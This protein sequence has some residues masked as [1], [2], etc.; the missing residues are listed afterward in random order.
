MESYFLIS[1]LFISSSLYKWC[2]PIL[3]GLKWPRKSCKCGF[4]W[5]L[6]SLWPQSEPRQVYVH[7]L[8]W[9]PLMASGWDV[10]YPG[11][12]C[13][14]HLGKCLGFQFLTD[15]VTKSNFDDVMEK[16]K[17]RLASWKG[18]LLNR[19]GHLCLTN[20]VLAST[21][22]YPMQAL[23]FPHSMCTKLDQ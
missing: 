4:A 3:W 22:I 19:G 12:M 2:S 17:S 7:L 15:Q 20:L 14:N 8:T 23:W 6:W 9:S 21:P 16:V 11:I 1:P 10:Q 13:T 18:K 5:I